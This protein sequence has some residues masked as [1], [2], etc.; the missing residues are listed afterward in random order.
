[1]LTIAETDL[2]LSAP[3]RALSAIDWRPG[4]S[5]KEAQWWRWDSAIEVGGA[6]PEGSRVIVQWRPAIGSAP[7][8]AN[9]TLLY[10][11]QR[12]YGID[13]YAAGRHTNKAGKG[14]PLCGKVIDT[15]V[16][17]H[18]WS[19]DGYGYVEPLNIGPVSLDELF[20]TFCNKTNL[21]VDGGYRPP[22]S[23][24][25]SLGLI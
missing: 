8:K 12:I 21:T 10:L 11:D 24:Q 25:L 5:K 4:I 2:F 15:I 23:Q 17:E 13:L 1:M 16:Q 6:V 20:G 22:P 7:D 9:F 3:K 19:D 18:T 14:R